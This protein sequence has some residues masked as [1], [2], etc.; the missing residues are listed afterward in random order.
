MTHDEW[1]AAFRSYVI[2]QVWREEG[3]HVAREIAEQ[4]YDEADCS[5]RIDFDTDPEVAAYGE[6]YGISFEDR[7]CDVS[8][9]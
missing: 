8:A 3:M 9:V 4:L 5:G 6:M 1:T 7:Y 2:A